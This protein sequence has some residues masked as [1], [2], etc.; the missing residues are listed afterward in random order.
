MVDFRIIQYQKAVMHSFCVFN[1]Q[2]WILDVESAY[3]KMSYRSITLCIDNHI[4]TII[5]L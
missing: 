2:C 3:F 5:L 1:R 4:D